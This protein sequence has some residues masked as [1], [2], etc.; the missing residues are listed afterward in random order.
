MDKAKAIA[1]GDAGLSSSGVTFTKAKLD[2]DDGTVVYEVEFFKGNTEYDY[3]INAV[4]G[5]IRDKDID[6]DDDWDDDWD[7]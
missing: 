5:K 3:E 1:L 4:S 2:K 7:D 6:I